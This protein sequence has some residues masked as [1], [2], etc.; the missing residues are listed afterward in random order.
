MTSWA[1]QEAK[2]FKWN[3]LKDYWK[4]WPMGQKMDT[5][6]EVLKEGF[7]SVAEIIGEG[8]DDTH[9]YQISK[10]TR[11]NAMM[12]S[13][14][15]KGVGR[16]SKEPEEPRELAEPVELVVENQGEGGNKNGQ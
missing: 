8:V 15:E 4:K 7:K 13:K 3:G 14:V 10:R 1:W 12:K 16:E 9:A 5:L 11:R 2:T 6:I